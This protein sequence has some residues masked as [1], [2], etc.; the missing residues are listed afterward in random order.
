MPK[1]AWKAVSLVCLALNLPLASRAQAPSGEAALEAQ[2]VLYSVRVNR[3]DAGEAR[4]LRLPGGG[5]LARVADLQ[6]WRLHLPAKA[7]TRYGGEEFIPLDQ[8][9]EASYRIDEERQAVELEFVPRSFLPTVISSSAVGASMLPALPDWGGYF[10]YDLVGNRRNGRGGSSDRLDG[11]FDANVFGPPGAG[12]ISFLGQN[13]LHN[14]GGQ[15]SK[16][17]FIRLDSTWTRDWPDEALTLQVGDSTG[18]S[19][20]WGRPVR[21]GG[22]RWG[23]NFATQAGFVTYPLPAIAGESALPSTIEL[24]I[25]DALQQNRQLPPGP[26]QISELPAVTGRG[27][28]RMV[29]RDLLGRERV[30]TQP[31]Y[32]STAL[33]REGLSDYG[34]EAGFVRKNYGLS[35]ND[36]GRLVAVATLRKGLSDSL[37]GEAR[38]EALRDQQ[39]T[40]V[41]GSILSPVGGIV[42]AALAH[43]RSPLGAGELL[44]LSAENQS[45]RGLSFGIRAQ[46]ASERFTQLGLQP[47][48]SA[49]RRQ[50]SANLGLPLKK[51]GSVGLSYT[52]QDNAGMPPN[53]IVSANYSVK[54]GDSLVMNV[55][56]FETL[57]GAR[58]RAFSVMLSLPLGEREMVTANTTLQS[59]TNQAQAQFQK[60]VPPGPGLGYRFQASGGDT[61]KRQEAG[62]TWQTG[63]GTYGLEAG[64]APGQTDYRLSVSGGTG[65]LDKRAF[66]SRR[67]TDSFAMAHAPGFPGV[68]I[69]LNGQLAGRTDADGVAVIP[70]L[71]SYQRNQV[72][73]DAGELPLDAQIETA[74]V[75]VIPYFRSGLTLKFSVKLSH[76]ALLSLVLDDGK[77][78]PVG[79]TVRIVGQEGDFPVGMRG[80]AYVTGLGESNQM[81]AVWNGQSCDFQINVRLD[82]GPTPY[83]GPV[84]CTGVKR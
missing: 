19:G 38:V 54:L 5:L 33:L 46:L 81:Q 78:A 36:Y 20:L 13:L 76:G 24:Y 26:F 53:E 41:G 30:I 11:T 34:L 47:G 50:L 40:G 51:L 42:S 9:E 7:P 23:R 2:W 58:T 29:V 22:I 21:M 32:A 73:I 6:E 48:Q 61:A 55:S 1:S 10:N 68:G 52:R 84:S 44:L 80:E 14:T 72:G 71:I 17:R 62:V 49:P 18:K 65:W 82:A 27:E 66:L 56:A 25:N 63:T 45:Q 77:P 16:R 15:Q 70:S 59:G 79:M 3:Q 8:F 64:R 60:S 57:S 75:T 12:T 74:Q 31:Y 35:S 28:I 69:Y 4:F 67:I 39:T 37:T 43:S 83:I